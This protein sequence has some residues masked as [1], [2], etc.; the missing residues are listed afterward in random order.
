MTTRLSSRGILCAMKTT[1]TTLL[2]VLLVGFGQPVLAT[3]DELSTLLQRGLFEE[4]GNRDIPA[5]IAAYESLIEAFERDRR[6]AATAVFRLGECYR[7]LGQT[8][9]AVAFYRKVLREFPEEPMLTK[10]SAENLT[11]LGTAEPAAGGMTDTA[12][13]LAAAVVMDEEEQE[14]RRLEAMVRNS[15]DLINAPSAGVGEVRTPLARAAGSGQLRVVQ[16]LLDHGAD[17]GLRTTTGQ[18]PL[19]LAAASGHRAIIELLL[20][21]EAAVDARDNSG[22]TALYES[23]GRGFV[24]V[25]EVLLAAGADVNARVDN[26][27]TPL[28]FAVD[29]GQSRI[30]SLLL[31]QGADPRAVAEDGRT[32]LMVAGMN[33]HREA[34]AKQLLAGGADPNVEDNEGRTALSYAVEKNELETVRALLG[35][36]ADPNTGRINLPLQV[37]ADRGS[38]AV[39][40]ALLQAGADPNRRASYLRVSE[41]HPGSSRSVRSSY[42]SIAPLYLAVR[43]GQPDV[44]RLLLARGADPNGTAPDGQ[45]LVFSAL[46]KSKVLELLVEAGADPEVV[47]PEGWSPLL[48]IT[49]HGEWVD[50]AEILLRAGANVNRL[51]PDGYAPLH[52]AGSVRHVGLLKL[53]L[54]HGAE[55]N[56]RGP[57][58]NTPLH[59]AIQHGVA[60]IV[61]GLLDAGADPN[62]RNDA[63]Q[64]PLDL[65]ETAAQSSGPRV[66]TRM[67][68]TPSVDVG[69]RVA[70]PARV[71]AGSGPEVLTREELVELLRQHGAKV[72]STPIP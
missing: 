27:R 53:L 56:V 8:N 39:V 19:H 60:E 65:A 46:D 30:V 24:A 48:L 58:G 3:T 32:P 5:A 25:A 13:G 4:E 26:G 16:F 15:P 55:V 10:L 6:L 1:A 18:T 35:N 20:Q 14:I 36:G 68:K 17:L 50:V 28:H 42:T 7:K 22:R 64:S 72:E 63:G 67:V 47:N 37:A 57:N 70:L 61:K 69:P 29:H 21:R 34:I 45:A 49:R 11:L 2:T 52:W 38:T 59:H 9:E 12:P 62:A 44:V 31:E 71:P 23:A 51:G 40:E 41:G 54:S 33:Q 66:P 43:S